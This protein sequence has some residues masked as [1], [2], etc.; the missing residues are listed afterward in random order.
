MTI[1]YPNGRQFVPPENVTSLQQNLTVSQSNRGMSLE[2]ELNQANSYYRTHGLANIHKKPT[3]IQIVNVNYPKR[4]AAKITEAY[5]RQASTTDYNG[6]Y[7]GKYIDFDAKETNQTTSFPLQNV[8]SHQVKHLAEIV[9]LG[10]VAFLIIRFTRLREDFV[11]P[12]SILIDYWHNQADGRKSI[13]Y[14]IIATHGKKIP[15]AI[16][17]TLPYLKAVD[18]LIKE[19]NI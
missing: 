4:S 17:L 12:A 10:G 9:K 1:N 16:N 11:L 13:P 3:P 8:H 5:F 14:Q 19:Q 6:I 7:Q 18:E 15:N 2:R